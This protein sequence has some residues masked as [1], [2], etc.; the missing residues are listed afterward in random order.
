M[1]ATF[2]AFLLTFGL[3]VPAQADGITVFAAA[4]LGDA[5]GDLAEAWEDETGHSVTLVLAGSSTL[6][7]Q[8]DAGAP[9]DLF[10]SANADWME[11]LEDRARVFPGSRFDLASNRLVLITAV[12]EMASNQEVTT[13]TDFDAMLGADGRLAVALPEAVPAGIYAK[14]ALTHLSHWDRVKDRLAPTDNAR[15]ALA[16]VALGEAPLGVVY[17][18]DALAEPHVHI[19]GVFPTSAHPAIRYPAAMVADTEDAD[20]STAFLDWLKA[21]AVQSILAMHGFLPPDEKE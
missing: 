5:M 3:T 10:L 6:A 8:I 21:D 13:L 2:R 11:W 17:A 15:A 1:I 14:A 12:P 9:A 20:T 7:R 4:S 19:A 16:L 18:T